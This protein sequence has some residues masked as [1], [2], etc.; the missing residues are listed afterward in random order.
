MPNVLFI[1]QHFTINRIIFFNSKM[2]I[3]KR[4]TLHL[5]LFQK[6]IFGQLFNIYLLST[7]KNKID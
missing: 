1:F 4:N 7:D 5:T 2:F 3:I 6:S